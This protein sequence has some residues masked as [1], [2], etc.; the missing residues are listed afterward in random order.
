MDPVEVAILGAVASGC[1][2]SFAIIAWALYSRFL[3]VAPPSRALVIFGRSSS[4]RQQKDPLGRTSRIGEAKF[5]VGGAAFIFPWTHS[6]ATL[7]LGTLDVDVPVRANLL[8]AGEAVTR[9]DLRIGAQVKISSDP[10]GLR[11][12][13]ENLLGK[14]EVEIRGLVR[15]V[16]EGHAHSVLA[17]ISAYLL[18]AEREKV[19]AEL[20][21]LS[22][23]DLVAM[24]IVVQSMGIKEIVRVPVNAGPAPSA[25]HLAEAL[26]SKDLDR[27]LWEIS[28]RLRKL[29]QKLSEL[30]R[31]ARTPEILPLVQDLTGASSR[32][33]DLR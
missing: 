32:V 27:T 19:A 29:E 20:Q 26:T 2:L 30:D 33:G 28:S 25:E 31:R 11:S 10:E 16:I 1:A 13:A 24:G 23:T 18:E 15:S 9:V 5:V 14:S 21:V 6:S 12:A 17:R 7:S 4:K 22:A 8:S 3:V